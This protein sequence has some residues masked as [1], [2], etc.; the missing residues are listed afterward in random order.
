[1]KTWILSAA[2]ALTLIVCV[3][4]QDS[5]GTQS[6]ETVAR[7]RKK[8]AADNNG[9]PANTDGDLPKI[10][11]KLSPKATKEQE[12]EADASFKAETNV[13]NLD[14]QVLDN[15]GNP[16]PNIP[17]DKFRILEDNVP[18]TLTQFSVG[19]APM[20]VAMV[21]EFSARYQA[22][23]SSGWA[24][25][26][27][28]S[29]GFVQTLKPEDYVAV[30]AYDLRSTILSDF[31]NERSKTMEAMQRL[32]IPGFSESNMFDALAD[33][34]DRMSK[35]EGRKAIL[36][37]ASGIDTFSKLT[38]DKARKS[39]QEAGVP[40]YSIEMLQ[41]QRIMAEGRMSESQNLDFLQ[42]DNELK[43]F[44]K[45]TAGQAFFPRFQGEL[46]SVFQ[47]ISQS[48]RNQYSLGY[49]PNNQAKDGKF[50]KLT[51][52]LVNPGTNEPL[53]VMDQKSGKPIKYTV[54]AKA[55]YTAPRAVE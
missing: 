11:S 24:Q 16:I 40:I 23:Y 8:P 33:T 22:Y 6:S 36:L 20:T 30:I 51:V 41:I 9:A 42:A 55:G 49:S 32:R 14:V 21:I 1:M 17:R 4:A 25:T 13:V 12:G 28:A 54:L 18:Q 10:P 52:Q 15:H 43:T 27:T 37:I 34:A 5:P 39:L 19:E 48:L 44:A 38:Y 53:R 29:Y 46:P 50:R 47:S 45:E 31:T 7:P 3:W 26:L 35:I 2:T